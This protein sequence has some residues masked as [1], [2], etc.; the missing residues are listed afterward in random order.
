MRGAGAEFEDGSDVRGATGED[1]GWVVLTSCKVAGAGVLGVRLAAAGPCG[2]AGVLGLDFAV[3]LS[4]S[5]PIS[6][7]R[8]SKEG[9]M[10]ASS[11]QHFVMM[12]M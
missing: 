7:A 11:A 3:T 6:L 8:S 2:V 4:W 1:W 10:R 12:L 5:S 9:L